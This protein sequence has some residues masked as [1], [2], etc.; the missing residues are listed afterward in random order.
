MGYHSGRH[1]PVYGHLTVKF[2]VCDRWFSS[3][4]GSTFP[5]RLYSMAGQA[6][7]NRRTSPPIYDLPSF[8]RHL[9]G[10]RGVCGRTSSMT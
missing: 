6:A 8:F 10:V 3:V 9:D 4:A 7:G 2:C 1:L 5:N